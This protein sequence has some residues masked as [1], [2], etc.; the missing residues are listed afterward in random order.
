VTS[1]SQGLSQ[2]TEGETLGTRL[3]FFYPSF[4]KNENPPLKC[5]WQV[6]NELGNRALKSDLK[7]TINLAED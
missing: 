7:S 6:R 1:R 4:K 5:N 3:K 2:M